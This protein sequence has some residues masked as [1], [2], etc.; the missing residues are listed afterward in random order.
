MEYRKFGNT[1]VIRMDRGEEII[2][3]LTDFCKKE[4]VQLGSVDALG[5]ADHAVV[6]LYDVS[7]R[8]FHT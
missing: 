8:E 6:G 5:A 3:I 1:Y 2:K 4:N 7:S